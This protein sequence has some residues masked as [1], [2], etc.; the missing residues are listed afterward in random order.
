[1][2]ATEHPIPTPIDRFNQR[3]RHIALAWLGITLPLSLWLRPTY[4]DLSGIYVG[5]LVARLGA[6]D[7]LYPVPAESS[8]Y[9]VGFEGSNKPA[10][11]R[12]AAEHHVIALT[13]YIQ[14]PWQAVL[15]Y[16]M[17]WLTFAQA[18]WAFV[19]VLI[20]CTWLISV[21]AGRTYELCAGG[22][23]RASGWITLAVAFSVLA[24]RCVR[25]QNMSPIVAALTGVAILNLLLPASPRTG[26]KSAAAIVIGAVM[27]VAPAMLLPLAAARRRWRLL[28]WSAVLGVGFL[29]LSLAVAGRSTFHEFFFTVGPTLGGSATNP[30]NKSLQG[31]LLR[32]VGHAPLP[33]SIML[34]FRAAQIAT[35]AAILFAIFRRPD[36]LHLPPYLFAAALALIAWLL[37][38]SPLCWEHY[39]VYFCPL[40][41]W[42]C[43]EGTLG[44]V[45]RITSVTA[46]ACHWLPLPAL[47]GLPWFHAPE[48]L[49]SYMLIGLILMLGLALLRLYDRAAPP[50]IS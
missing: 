38:F 49:N 22:T 13:P 19:A 18:H 45:R 34:P 4:Q 46:I 48:P 31:A 39:F 32:T 36:R 17:G 25:V 23:S 50:T 42:L 28:T 40:W 21:Q 43:W 11:E 7:A 8:P 30:G 35:L 2:T 47:P 37:I 9:Y 29:A 44:P 24:Y 41:G 20:A 27:K 14:P 6:W 10:L 33:L 12:L 3:C 15:Y 26:L 16:P 5:G 1:M